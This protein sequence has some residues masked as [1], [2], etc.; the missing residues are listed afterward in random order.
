MNSADGARFQN[1]LA[2]GRQHGAALNDSVEV[3]KDDRTGYSLRI[4]PSVPAVPASDDGFSVVTCPASVTLSYLNALIDGPLLSDLSTV[5]FSPSFPPSFISSLPPHVIGRF[6]L[7]QQYLL[8]PAS[9]WH[10]YIRALPQP[11][12][13]SSWALPAFWPEEDIDFLEG[14]NAEVAVREVQTNVKGEFKR[15]RKILKEVEFPGWQDYSRLLY[16]WA[17]CMFT[18]RSFRP[19]TVFSE[20]LRRDLREQGV[21]Q[22]GVR[23]DDFSVLMPVMD[24]G[25]HDMRIKVKWDTETEE[26][27]CRFLSRDGMR[28][29]EQIFNNYG[30]KTNSELLLG[31]G[32][33]VPETEELHNDYVHV[34]MRQLEGA[35]EAGGGGDEKPKDFLISLRPMRDSSSLAGLSRLRLRAQED[36]Q[37]SPALVH[38]EDSLVWDLIVSQAEHDEEIFAWPTAADVALLVERVKMALLAKMGYDYERILDPEVY[39]DGELALIPANS[40]QELA[41]AYR[42]QCKKV[43]ETA[44]RS[45][46][47][48]I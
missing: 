23:D 17:F 24:I 3:Y 6:Y 8:G 47:G 40:N 32:F 18:S 1:L 14:T 39:E 33:I 2:W 43:L 22:E 7:I 13:L 16:N 42:A 34:R 10:P 5:S 38:V 31:Y 45:M 15:A 12:H 27:A 37:V 44:I 26:R 36:F 48:R 20:K 35:N 11:E 21:L 9:F 30:M 4:K 41:S 28:P 25:N 19:T 46:G 29:K